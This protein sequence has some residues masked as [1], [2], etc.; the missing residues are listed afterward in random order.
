MKN[1]KKEPMTEDS[2]EL[3]AYVYIKYKEIRKEK[4]ETT[5]SGKDAV[6]LTTICRRIPLHWAKG[7]YDFYI[8]W[9]HPLAVK[10]KYSVGVFHYLLDQM[11]DDPLKI[12]HT[13]WV[14]KHE[15]RKG[16]SKVQKQDIVNSLSGGNEN[17]N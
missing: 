12:Q 4:Y 10:S 2:K 16:L 5:S 9:N 3:R 6:L 13:H 14:Q 8:Q 17:D 1:C 11:M 15:E 7:L